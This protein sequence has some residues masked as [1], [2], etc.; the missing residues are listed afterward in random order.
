MTTSFKDPQHLPLNI[1]PFI[2]L[3]DTRIK[4]TVHGQIEPSRYLW[5]LH[6]NPIEKKTCLLG[7][8]LR[9]GQASPEAGRSAVRTVRACGPDGPRARRTD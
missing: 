6:N 7:T 5:L 1:Y 4:H 2:F 3:L 9:C 8:K